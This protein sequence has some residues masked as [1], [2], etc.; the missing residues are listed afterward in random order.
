MAN[1]PIRYAFGDDGGAS[2]DAILV[3][4]ATPASLGPERR[5]YTGGALLAHVIDMLFSE[6]LFQ[7]LRR[8]HRL[9]ERLGALEAL[10]RRKGW[11]PEDLHEV[12]AALGWE[13][14]RAMSIVSIRPL[15]PLPGTLFSGFRDAG[16]RR[17]Y[18]AAGEERARAVLDE[19]GW[20]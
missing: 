4:A 5:E 2:I 18:V 7:D 20:R 14:R 15:L 16:V 17:A 13:R 10:A 9:N 6:W 1:T 19:L 3:V 8:S 11:S 12:R